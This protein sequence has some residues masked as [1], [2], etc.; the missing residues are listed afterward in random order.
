[1]TERRLPLGVAEVHVVIDDVAG[2]LRHRRVVPQSRL[3]WF[4]QDLEHSLACS[5]AGL[6][7]LV[8][9]MQT[10]DRLVEKTD[11]SEEGDQLTDLD[12]AM[13]DSAGTE[14]YRQHQTDR[15]EE[16]HRP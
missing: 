14:H 16:N 15:G 4:I 2:D 11:Q 12:S 7:Q 9:L 10:R 6:H 8:E 1:M 5:A 13:D 3:L